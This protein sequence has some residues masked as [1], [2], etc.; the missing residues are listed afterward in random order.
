MRRKTKLRLVVSN[1]SHKYQIG[2]SVI[3]QEKGEVL[4]WRYIVKSR[5]RRN[6]ICYYV[7]QE[8][9]EDKEEFMLWAQGRFRSPDVTVSED[10]IREVEN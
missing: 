7:L 10:Q 1:P 3:V 5:T 9:P 6:G 4:K 8:H 2:Q